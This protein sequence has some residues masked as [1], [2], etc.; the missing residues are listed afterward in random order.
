[1]LCTCQPLNISRKFRC[2]LQ[3][4]NGKKYFM[5]ILFLSNDSDLILP[6]FILKTFPTFT[7]YDE[8]QGGLKIFKLHFRKH[9]QKH[10]IML[11]AQIVKI[12]WDRVALSN[13]GWSDGSVHTADSIAS[14]D[15]EVTLFAPARSPRIFDDPII[16]SFSENRFRCPK[17]S[18]EN[19]YKR[20][21]RK[22]KSLHTKLKAFLWCIH[23][24]YVYRCSLN[25]TRIIS[26]ER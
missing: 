11:M 10:A 16:L 14:L 6:L 1:M 22:F 18:D 25:E 9:T 13:S 12:F 17:S 5:T 24:V 23:R 26:E 19:S 21:R 2:K 7:T 20:K 15:P 3:S 4:K 8:R